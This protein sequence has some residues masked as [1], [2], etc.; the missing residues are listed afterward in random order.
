MALTT[1]L[2][3]YWKF[4][5]SNSNDS[6]GSNNGTDTA[7]TYSSGN[8]KIGNGA[9]FNGSSSYIL[10]AASVSSGISNNYSVSFWC[11]NTDTSSNSNV[12]LA[13]DS[14]TTSNRN[15]QITLGAGTTNKSV[16]FIRFT[17][18]NSLVTNITGSVNI[19]D[20]SWHH[21]VCTFD[22]AVGS[23][24]YI[25][26][27]NVASDSVTTINNTNTGGKGVIGAID[28]NSRS[29]F[30]NGD[31]DEMAV[32]T[33]TLSS[34]EVTDLYNAGAGNQYPFN[35]SITV[36]PSALSAVFASQSTTVSG[37]AI[38]N[39]SIINGVLSIQSPSI[40][41]AVVTSL[42]TQSAVFSIPTVNVITPDSQVIP[43]VMSSVFSTQAPYINIF[44][45]DVTATPSVQN[46]TFSIQTPTTV[47]SQYITIQASVSSALF[48]TN[49]V[50]IYTEKSIDV[51]VGTLSLYFSV[52][53][54]KKVGG[55]WS[56]VPRETGDW[57]PEARII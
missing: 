19:N 39:S 22:S 29:S 24:I 6:V 40:I 43:S 34:T 28:Y 30:Q 16:R 33:R 1:N 56:K 35:V 41:T 36:T 10:L 8:G 53:T 57:T 9:G 7:I 54:P 48:S 38:I 17:S 4:D 25:D 26:G 12:F 49:F 5:S 52:I 15:F 31:I 50:T 2:A 55:L 42:T 45:P 20:G 47:T 18:G 21:V 27:T 3:S 14:P 46:L 32:W 51:P 37:Q 13:D 23:I 11:K 44:F